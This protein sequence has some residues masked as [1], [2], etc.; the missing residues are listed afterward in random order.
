MYL[1]LILI[2]VLQKTTKLCKE[3]I[4]QLKILKNAPS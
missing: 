2:D 1:W 4:L 3:I